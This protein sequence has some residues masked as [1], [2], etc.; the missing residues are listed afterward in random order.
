MLG[1]VVSCRD[2][3]WHN[4]LLQISCQSLGSDNIPG[5]C[6]FVST[7][8]E[9]YYRLPTHRVINPVAGSSVNIGK[10][11]TGD[12][13]YAQITTNANGSARIIVKWNSVTCIDF[14]D[15]TPILGGNPGI[16]GL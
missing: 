7:G 16:L 12:I 14:T 15:T 9:N 6:A 4:L 2:G 10:P 1:N 3:F 8:Q 11:K 5:L 13:F